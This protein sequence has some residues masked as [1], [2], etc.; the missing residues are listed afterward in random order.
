MEGREV[1]RREGKSRGKCR[2]GKE[3]EDRTPAFNRTNR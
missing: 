2:G 1:N 3:E